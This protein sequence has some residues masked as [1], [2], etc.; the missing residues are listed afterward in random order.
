VWDVLAQ[1]CQEPGGKRLKELLGQYAP[2]WLVQ[3]PTLISDEERE[4]LQRKV[5]GATR[6]RMLREIAEAVEAL[7]AQRPLVLI[8]EDLQWADYSTLD[9]LAFLAW[10]RKKPARLLVIGTY[11]PVDVIV[12]EHPLKGIKQELQIHGYWQELKLGYLREAAVSQYLAA[13]FS[14]SQLPAELARIIH[15]RTDGNPFFMVSVADYLVAQGLITQIGGQ[16]ELTGGVEGVEVEVP[17]SLRQ[18][19]ERQIDELDPEEQQML[20]VA[21]VV[22][23]EFSA[24]AVAAGLGGEVGQV[25]E[26]CAR[27]ARRGQFLRLAGTEEWPDGT[28]AARYG[29]IHVL[30]QKVVYE[31][32]PPGRRIGLHQRIGERKEAAYSNRVGEIAAELAAHFERGRDYR[33]AVQYLGQAGENAIRKHAHREAMDHLRACEKNVCLVPLET[34]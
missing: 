2:M 14:Q 30:Y 17:E 13:K 19:I 4:A 24:A 9:L 29:F 7:T 31:R 23:T 32:V 18:I 1:L 16:W 25:E 6:E 33:Q 28:V 20:E 34:S 12:H 15:R 11:R 22:G 26:R 8:L 21:S 5:M 10:R 3:M 27:L